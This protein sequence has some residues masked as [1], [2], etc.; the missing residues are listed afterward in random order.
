MQVN[1]AWQ[2]QFNRFENGLSN[3]VQSLN[4]RSAD[5]AFTGVSEPFVSVNP[6]NRNTEALAT[7]YFVWNPDPIVSHWVSGPTGSTTTTV[8]KHSV[9]E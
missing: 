5:G 8:P 6:V 7:A 4:G 9:F 3:T 1:G 2:N